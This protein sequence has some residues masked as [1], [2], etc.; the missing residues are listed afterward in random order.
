ML[1]RLAPDAPEAGASAAATLRLRDVHKRFGRVSVLRG[2]D[3][4]VVPGEIVSLVGENGTGK[5]TLV[6]CVAGTYQPDRGTIEV[7]GVPLVANPFGARSQGVA[8]V[9]QDLALCDN[10]NVVAHIFL[11]DAFR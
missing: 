6:Q 4:D 11:G 3:L 9:W 10:L 7:G 8:V 1:E 5:S 2:V